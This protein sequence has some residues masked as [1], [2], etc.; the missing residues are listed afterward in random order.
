MSSVGASLSVVDRLRE[1]AHGQLA[2]CF[3]PILEW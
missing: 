3:G 1:T 2:W